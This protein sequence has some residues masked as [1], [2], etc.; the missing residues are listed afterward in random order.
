MRS[1]GKGREGRG[2]REGIYQADII[3][4]FEISKIILMPALSSNIGRFAR[5]TASVK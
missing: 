1:Q 2:E 3:G 4:Y 5:V